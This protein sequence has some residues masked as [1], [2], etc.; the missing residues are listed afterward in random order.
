MRDEQR[1]D[2]PLAGPAPAGAAGAEDAAGG[3]APPPPAG[4]TPA[5]RGSR[6]DGAAPPAPRP[7]GGVN[8]NT[9]SAAELEA[10]PGIGEVTARRILE[11]R[12]AQGRIGSLDDLR[13]AGIPEALLR[14]AAARLVFE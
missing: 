7:P 2:I 9:A 4:L 8:V 13:R 6:P 14:R 10:L 11:V 5:S 1:L 12:A 3:A